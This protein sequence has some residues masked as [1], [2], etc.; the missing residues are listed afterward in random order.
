MVFDILS[1]AGKWATIL[2][3]LEAF[4]LSLIPLFILYKILQGLYHFVPKVAPA[5]RRAHQQMLKIARGIKRSMALI[6]A[7]F[8]WAHS[9]T[10]RLRASMTSLCRILQ[11]R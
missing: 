1:V 11:G 3:A 4:L 7:P 8:I 9:V 6:A 2:L 5:L 10:A